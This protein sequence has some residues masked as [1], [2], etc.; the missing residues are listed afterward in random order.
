M[1]AVSAHCLEVWAL[2]HGHL[3]GQQPAGIRLCLVTKDVLGHHLCKERVCTHLHR[4]D[5]AGL[6]LNYVVWPFASLTQQFA[7]MRA[8]GL[9][10]VCAHTHNTHT[11]THSTV[12][13]RLPKGLMKSQGTHMHARAR[14]STHTIACARLSRTAWASKN[15]RGTC[16]R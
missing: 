16:G 7:Q 12:C 4:H 8:L 9:P 6:H 2:A 3:P 15:A 1:L 10:Y 13:A 11:H 5:F 14:T